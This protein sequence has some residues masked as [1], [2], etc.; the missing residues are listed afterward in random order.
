M[1]SRARLSIGRA[2]GVGGTIEKVADVKLTEG[3]FLD[4]RARWWVQEDELLLDMV[5][6]EAPLE[7][8]K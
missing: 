4:W 7:E 5:L 2:G 1:A 6:R 8:R 3:D